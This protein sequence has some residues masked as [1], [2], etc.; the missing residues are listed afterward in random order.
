MRLR[1]ITGIIIRRIDTMTWK[2]RLKSYAHGLMR[3][4]RNVI[5]R[6]LPR[7]PGHGTVDCVLVV[8][9]FPRIGTA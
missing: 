6:R 3:P 9:I 4:T 7:R 8:N 5:D 1:I 2:I